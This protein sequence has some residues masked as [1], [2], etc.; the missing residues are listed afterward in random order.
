MSGKHTTD[1]DIMLAKLR[2]PTYINNKSTPFVGRSIVIAPE[3]YMVIREAYFQLTKNYQSYTI[4]FAL[5]RGNGKVIADQVSI[6]CVM[7]RLDPNVIKFTIGQLD[8]NPYIGESFVIGYNSKFKSQGLSQEYTSYKSNMVT[9][10]D[11]L[12]R[13]IVSPQAIGWVPLSR[14]R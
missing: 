2:H 3:K 11:S 14:D 13:G 9:I 6:N 5:V 4:F 1:F 12:R 8:K 10:I 7:H